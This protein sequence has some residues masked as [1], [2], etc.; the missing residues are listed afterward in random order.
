MDNVMCVFVFVYKVGGIF[1][2]L[3]I[4]SKFGVLIMVER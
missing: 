1:N 2:L 3:Y 4:F